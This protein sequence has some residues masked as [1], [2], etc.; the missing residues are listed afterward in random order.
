MKSFLALLLIATLQQFSISALVLPK[1]DTGCTIGSNDPSTECALSIVQV[2]SPVSLLTMTNEF[3]QETGEVYRDVRI[4]VASLNVALVL[5]DITPFN[6]FYENLAG[7]IIFGGI[8]FLKA[9]VDRNPVAMSMVISKAYLGTTISSIGG[10]GLTA[11]AG[12]IGG[13]IG[14]VAGPFVASLIEHWKSNSLRNYEI[15]HIVLYGRPTVPA[16]I[17]TDHQFVLPSYLSARLQAVPIDFWRGF[18]LIHNDGFP[19]SATEILKLIGGQTTS[20]W[21]EAVITDEAFTAW[22]DCIESG[23]LTL[24]CPKEGG[25]K[26]WDFAFRDTFSKVVLKNG[27]E[28]SGSYSAVGRN[29]MTL[30][31]PVCGDLSHK[32][33]QVGEEFTCKDGTKYTAKFEDSVEYRYDSA[34]SSQGVYKFK[35]SSGT[36]DNFCARMLQEGDGFALRWGK[37]DCDQIHTFESHYGSE[38]S[39]VIYTELGEKK[40]FWTYEYGVIKVGETPPQDADKQFILNIAANQLGV[41]DADGGALSVANQPKSYCFNSD[42]TPEEENLV[43]GIELTGYECV[44]NNIIRPASFSFTATRSGHVP[45]NNT[46]KFQLMNAQGQCHAAKQTDEN[47]LLEWGHCSDSSSVFTW[48]RDDG[49]DGTISAT[50]SDTEYFWKQDGDKIVLSDES[51]TFRVNIERQWLKLVRDWHTDNCL[52]SDGEFLKLSG[53]TEHCVNDWV[54]PYSV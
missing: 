29:L 17:S 47:I 20:K 16:N 25:V 52:H 27:T 31:I 28:L 3:L 36:E 9:I 48:K 46:W 41:R 51:S 49:G 2:Q 15:A 12:P 14:A 30:D 13:L 34:V 19:M 4:S 18:Y 37:S 5:A 24:F 42:E 53:N 26:G 50:F 22:H 8:Q 7:A 21:N 1:R 38:N 43:K 11:I 39:A 54:I 10:W 23:F 32:V 45:E 33:V 40:L 44:G 6:V 35:L